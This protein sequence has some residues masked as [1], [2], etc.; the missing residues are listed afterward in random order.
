MKTFRT[1]VLLV[2]ACFGGMSMLRAQMPTVTQV[3]FL[4]EFSGSTTGWG[5]TVNAKVYP[6][7]QHSLFK[8]GQL[9]HLVVANPNVTAQG[10]TYTL[11]AN[12]VLR[13][14]LVDIFQL[15]IEDI[16]AGHAVVMLKCDKEVPCSYGPDASCTVQHLPEYNGQIGCDGDCCLNPGPLLTKIG[17]SLCELC[18]LD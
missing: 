18:Q 11:Y 15:S 13:E 4:E 6:N 12:T 17:D 7:T 16:I 14:H 5:V 1:L 2:F 8:I 10:V 9:G 3:H